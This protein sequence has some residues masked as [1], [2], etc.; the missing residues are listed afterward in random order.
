MVD[1]PQLPISSNDND[2]LATAIARAARRA[3][4]RTL[5]A[6]L[7]L[8]VSGASAAWFVASHRILPVSAAIAIG[9]FGAGGLADRILT[10]ERSHVD[11]DQTLLVGFRVI[12]WLSVAVGGCSA[13]IT[14]AWM[15]FWTLDGSRLTWH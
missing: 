8:G 14:V 1:A 2:T 15:L 4:W 6:C 13:I 11:A 3:S 9:A 10:D 7:I 5:L 12:R